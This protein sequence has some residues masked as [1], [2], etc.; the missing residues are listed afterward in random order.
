MMTSAGSCRTGEVEGMRTVELVCI[1]RLLRM[2][3]NLF[4]CLCGDLLKVGSLAKGSLML[5]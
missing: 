1:S 4:Y 2:G 5:G 3:V